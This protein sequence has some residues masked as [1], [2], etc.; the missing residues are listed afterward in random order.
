MDDN[1]VIFIFFLLAILFLKHRIT[2]AHTYSTLSSLNSRVQDIRGGSLNALMIYVM[3]WT[4]FSSL[5]G[6][7]SDGVNAL[8]EVEITEEDVHKPYLDDSG[9]DYLISSNVAVEAKISN[10]I[11][12]DLYSRQ[13]L[14]YGR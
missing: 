7:A 5:E 4:H 9:N 12:T 10:M 1:N 3:I 11:D 2:D 13:L 14:V 6:G 8:D